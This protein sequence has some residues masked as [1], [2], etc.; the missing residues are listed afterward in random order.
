MADSGRRTEILVVMAIAEV[1]GFKNRYG[2]EP[3]R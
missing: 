2:T 3:I 1:D